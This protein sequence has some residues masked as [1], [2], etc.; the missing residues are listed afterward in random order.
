MSFL[1]EIKSKFQQ[2]GILTQVIILNVAMFLTVNLVGNIS[3]VDLLPYTALP[4]GGTSF[5]FKFWTLF[6]YMFTHAGLM[7][8]FWNMFLFYFMSQI[9]FTIMG[10]KKMLYVYVMSGLS[11]G[12]LVLILGM[13]FP[14]SFGNSI[15]LGAS[16]AVLGV[17][18][19]MALYSPNYSVFLFGAFEMKY[20]YFY[21][22]TFAASTIIDL[23]VNTGGKISHIGGAL[24]GL[25]Y[26][27]F[28]KQGKDLSNI[29]FSFKKKK[30]LKVVSYNTS[31]AKSA[32]P[33]GRSDDEIMNALLDKIS[34][35]GYESLNKTEKDELFKLSQKK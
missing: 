14:E 9:F 12:A 35:S 23:S 1:T 21:L 17:G 27:Y 33:K 26:G 31:F 19:V 29:S 34:K 22:L 25:A 30:K 18:A 8:L 10:E 11:G 32:N 2:Q 20:K 5:L 6:T 28:L 16:A 3:H 7:H 24:F 13:I 4:I 15:L